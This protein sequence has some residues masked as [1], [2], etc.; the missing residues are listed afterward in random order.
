MAELF[1]K[2]FVHFMWDDSLEGKEGF[3]ADN[4]TDLCRRVNSGDENFAECIRKNT[5]DCAYDFPFETESEYMFRFF[6][7][8][9]NYDC[10]KGLAE[11]KQIQYRLKNEGTGWKDCG[12]EPW[13]DDAYDYRIK[14]EEPKSRRMTY[15]ELAEWLAKGNGQYTTGGTIYHHIDYNSCDN[16]DNHEIKGYKIRRWGSDEWIEP[17]V[18]EYLKDCGNRI[19]QEYYK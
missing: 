17:T 7:Y 18:E 12:T 13:W 16:A 14:P 9:P 6:Y 11:G 2:R 10:K 8:D 1:D 5:E 3:F 19:Y 4:V 15:R